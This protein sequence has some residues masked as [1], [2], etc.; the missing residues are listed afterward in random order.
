MGTAAR[1][2]AGLFQTGIHPWAVKD[3]ESL[4]TGLQCALETMDRRVFNIF[5]TGLTAVTERNLA[6]PI[7]RL[8]VELASLV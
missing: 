4:Q 8:S 7:G 3:S 2:A 5:E 1:P 6:P